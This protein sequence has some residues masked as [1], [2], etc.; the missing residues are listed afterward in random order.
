MQAANIKE[1]ATTPI[2]D[3]LPCLARCLQAHTPAAGRNESSEVLFNAAIPQSNPNSSHLHKLSRSSSVS[4]SQKIAASSSVERLVSH[5]H[6]VHQN[7]TFGSNAHA[8]DDQTAT[9][10]E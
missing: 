5:I 6:R 4:A 8:H 3:F 10:S 9:F 1:A 7:I 2:S